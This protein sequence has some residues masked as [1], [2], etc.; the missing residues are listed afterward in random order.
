MHMH[1]SEPTENSTLGR[2]KIPGCKK[3]DLQEE[4]RELNINEF[5]IFNDLEHLSKGIKQMWELC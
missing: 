1:L 3:L 2:I 4:L 5:S